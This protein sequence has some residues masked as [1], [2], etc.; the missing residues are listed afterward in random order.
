MHT[1]ASAEIGVTMLSWINTELKYE[2]ARR[3]AMKQR[4]NSWQRFS[5]ATR[6]IRSGLLDIARLVLL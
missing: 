3:H 2:I 5:A 4:T 1:V 6:K